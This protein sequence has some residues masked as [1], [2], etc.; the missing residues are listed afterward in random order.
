MK[1]SMC[2]GSHMD[3]HIRSGLRVVYFVHVYFLLRA[4]LL[5]CYRPRAT[6]IR[7]C[8][9]PECP[10]K[11]SRGTS[12]WLQSRESGQEVA[13]KQVTQP[14]PDLACSR[15]GVDPAELSEIAVDREEFQAL[16]GLQPHSSDPPLKKSGHENAWMN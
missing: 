8:M 3:V 13:K 12:Y 5:I 1:F 16:L 9:C 11:D 10:R 7:H 15:L 6:L 2:N 14:H 4:P